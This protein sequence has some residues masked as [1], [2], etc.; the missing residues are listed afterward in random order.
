MKRHLP[1]LLL[2]LLSFAAPLGAQQTQSP[3][4]PS[5]YLG[6]PLGAD[7]RLPDWDAVRGYF[8]ELA[9]ASPRVEFSQ[10]GT[11]TE[12][13]PFGLAVISS[14]A[15]LA[16]IEELKGHAAV[17]A[18]PR[19]HDAARV[20]QALS[21]G[22][23]FLMISCNMHSTETASPQFAMRFAHQLATSDAEPWRSAREKLVV[24]LMPTINPDGLDHV[25]HWYQEHV[26]TPYEGTGLTQL[27]QY[28]AGHDNNRD[29]FALTQEETRIVTR[30][31]YQEWHPQV[32]WDVHEQGNRA[33]RMFVP[34]FR[35][36]L[37]PHLDPLVITGIDALGSRGLWDMTRDGYT[38]VSTGVS[39]DMWWNGGNRNVPVRHN[40]IGLLTEAASVDIAS[41][42][43]RP[44]TSLRAPSGVDGGY[45]PSHR[46]PA[47]WPGGWWRIGDIIDYEHAFARSLVGSLAREPRQWMSNALL[48]ARR[49]IA[50]ARAFPASAWLLPSDSPDREAARRLAQILLLSGVEVYAA[51]DGVEADGRG[52]PAGTLVIPMDQPYAVHV[53]DLFSL[54]VYPDGDR[55]YDVAGWTLPLLFG[56][57]RVEVRGEVEGVLKRVEDPVGAVAGFAGRTPEARGLGGWLDAG[58]GQAWL[59]AWRSLAD[60]Q[61]L[62]AGAAGGVLWLG[63]GQESR[64]AAESFVAHQTVARLP[65]I[66]VYAPWS[67]SMDEGWLRWVFDRFGVRYV[68]VR[69]EMLRAG[70]LEDFLDVLVI[71]SVSG[72]QLDAGRSPLGSPPEISGGLAPEGAVAIEEFVRGGGR[73]VTL[74]SSS[75]W[76]VELF[77][78]PLVDAAVDPD[79]SCPGSVVRTIPEAVSG[80]DGLRAPASFLLQGLP[81]SVPVF[82]SG[83]SAW[84]IDEDAMKRYGAPRP[85]VLLRYAP[86]RTLLSGYMAKP[87]AVAG[88]PAWVRAAYGDGQVHLFGFRPQYRGW[89]EAAFHLLFRAVLLDE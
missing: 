50:R 35:D 81:D 25:S 77:G 82:F 18:D 69:N 87:E 64:R 47:P 57:R 21:E 71:A 29:W 33:E 44:A 42:V 26:G 85:Q 75:R 59:E 56:L 6:H 83:S 24:L 39:Y 13:R 86:T 1:S 7:F 67:G 37:N 41:P 8:E 23:L 65:R 36:P 63:P 89:S 54:Q 11:T 45:A 61:P 72:G 60:G 76:A 78:L 30:L 22:R 12:G 2:L 88:A 53:Q 31:L 80:E 4:D 84:A 52:Y 74:G 49:N 19:G 3:R 62:G 20:E 55:P 66:G 58:N 70:R 5:A 16:R 27:Y 14:E 32:Y 40:I 28:Y 46:F 10:V 48:A 15:N 17:L 38:G 34:P 79:F 9:V 73:L 43:W 51:P 68:S